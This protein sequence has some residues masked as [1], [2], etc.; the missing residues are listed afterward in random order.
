MGQMKKLKTLIDS[1]EKLPDGNFKESV[2]ED[3]EEMKSLFAEVNSL[4]KMKHS[5]RELKDELYLDE[6]EY[7]YEHNQINEL[8]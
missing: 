5:L 3:M 6:L 4:K 2:K 1:F 7:Q 8:D